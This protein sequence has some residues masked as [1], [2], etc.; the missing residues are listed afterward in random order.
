MLTVFFQRSLKLLAI[1]NISLRRLWFGAKLPPPTIFYFAYGANLDAKRFEKYGANVLPVGVGYLDD[2]SLQFT[3]PCEYI[4]KGYASIETEP[5]ERVWG[6]LY[7]VDRAALLLLDIIE[8]AFL[9]HYDRVKV[10]VKLAAGE[11]HSSFTYR[12]PLPTSGLMPSTS[13]KTAILRSS[14]SH[15]FPKAYIERI[16]QLV[17]KDTFELDPSYSI[18]FPRWRRPLP[19]LFSPLYRIHDRMAEAVSN[20]LRF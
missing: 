20:L 18:T 1:A 6:Y 3:M 19:G 17:A 10:D 11:I 13:Y 15:N 5:G 16:D 4:G 2:Y 14:R 12:T 8:Y 7:K 9:R